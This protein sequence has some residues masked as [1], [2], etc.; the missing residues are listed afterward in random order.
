MHYMEKAELSGVSKCLDAGSWLWKSRRLW[1]SRG[2]KALEAGGS[3]LAAETGSQV[4][5]GTLVV[6]GLFYKNWAINELL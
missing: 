1:Q 6:A 5:S 2:H 3:R 4:A